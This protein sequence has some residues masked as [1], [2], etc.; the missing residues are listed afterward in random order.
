LSRFSDNLYKL[1]KAHNADLKLQDVQSAMNTICSVVEQTEQPL[2]L[3]LYQ[4]IIGILLQH[5]IITQLSDRYILHITDE[6]KDLYHEVFETHIEPR[7]NSIFNY[8]Q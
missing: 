1:L 4:Y 6:F 3:S 5:N 7:Q 2:S 8:E